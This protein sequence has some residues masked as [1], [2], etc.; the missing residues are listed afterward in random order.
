VKIYELLHTVNASDPIS[1]AV[2]Q[3]SEGTGLGVVKSD[4]TSGTIS[5]VVHR[6]R[7]EKPSA[8]ILAFNIHLTLDH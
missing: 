4:T 2:V 8:G 3:C 5:E 6:D 7:E 1:L